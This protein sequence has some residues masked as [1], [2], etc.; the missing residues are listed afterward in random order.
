MLEIW[1]EKSGCEGRMLTCRRV[2]RSY[3]YI[4]ELLYPAT[5]PGGA[6]CFSLPTSFPLQCKVYVFWEV[7]RTH[8]TE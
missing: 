6:H 4:F 5:P 1:K 7:Q 3:M 8:I 2:Q